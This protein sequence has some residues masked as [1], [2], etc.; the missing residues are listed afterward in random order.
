M[1]RLL[2]KYPDSLP[3]M[4][5]VG[6]HHTVAGSFKQALKEY[7]KVF[8]A[9]PNDPFVNLYIGVGYLSQVMSRSTQNRHSTAA[10]AWA[11]LRRYCRLRGEAGRAEGGY[12]LARALHQLGLP[13]L[14]LPFYV[15]VLRAPSPAPET[16]RE[17]AFN[18]SLLLR[19]QGSPHLARHVLRAYLTV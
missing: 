11:F 13:S 1:A 18:L 19:A 9:A 3:L 10:K 16:K 4:L 7:F 12:N 2:E 14:A 8:R 17:A 6:H 15:A 5:L